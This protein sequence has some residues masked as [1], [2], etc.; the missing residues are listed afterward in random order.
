MWQIKWFLEQL[1][2]AVNDV[3][4]NASSVRLNESVVLLGLDTNFKSDDTFD[5][6]VLLAK[7]F[8][9]KCKGE[10]PKVSFV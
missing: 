4:T 7:C 8:I 6:I 2:T 9:Y 3:G 1:E 10:Y 5:L